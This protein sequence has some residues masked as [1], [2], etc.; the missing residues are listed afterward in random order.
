MTLTDASANFADY[1]GA[2]WTIANIGDSADD[3]VTISVPSGTT[4]KWLTGG[5]MVSVAGAST[6]RTI[7]A[8][9]VVTI[10]IVDPTDDIYYITGSG[11][12]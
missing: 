6:A 5:S 12:A 2:T 7:S 8:G 10:F 4:L 11:I 1:G 3:L 9:G